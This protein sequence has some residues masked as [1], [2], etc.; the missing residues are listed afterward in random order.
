MVAH[1]CKILTIL[2]APV[3][4]KVTTEKILPS[5]STA[6]EMFA[7]KL[8]VSFD[9]TSLYTKIPINDTLNIIK[10]YV[11]SDGQYTRNAVI[12]HDKI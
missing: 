3:K 12:P 1:Y 6:S 9:I 5:F 11:N 7:L 4:M 8:M 10:R 2:K